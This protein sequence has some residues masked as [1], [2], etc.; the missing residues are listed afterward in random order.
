MTKVSDAFV[1]IIMELYKT[2]DVSNLI[3]NLNTDERNLLNSIIYMAGLNKKITTNTNETVSGLKENIKLL[4]VKYLQEMIT[5][6]F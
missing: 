3:K 5:L 4:K 1:E 2:N 6:N